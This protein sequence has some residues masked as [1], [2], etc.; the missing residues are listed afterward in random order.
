MYFDKWY[1]PGISEQGEE[2]DCGA[3]Y[4]CQSTDPCCIPSGMHGACQIN[5]AAG[6]ECHPSQGLC[7][8]SECK[9]AH[10]ET[11]GVVSK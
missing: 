9:Y 5:R 4:L 3:K 2:C 1:S 7:C 6:Y 11:I 8:T 10:L